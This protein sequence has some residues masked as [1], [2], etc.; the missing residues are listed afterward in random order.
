MKK[1]ITKITSKKVRPILKIQS[2]I[3][4]SVTEYLAMHGFLQALPVMLS[5]ETDPLAHPV[6]EAEIDYY[7]QKLKLTK[8]MILHKFVY[9]MASEID[10]IFIVS[11]NV[12][13]EPK[14]LSESQRHLIEFSQVDIEFKDKGKHFFMEFMEGLVVHVMQQVSS[15]CST[16]LTELGRKLKI[17][18]KPFRFYESKELK[19]NYGPDYEK[20]ISRLSDEPFWIL[21][22][23]REFYD[24][25]DTEEKGYHHNYDLVWPEGF[26]EALSG[27]EREYKYEEIVRKMEERDMDLSEYKSFLKLAKDRYLKRSVGGGLGVE[28]FVR[29]M[30][31][32]KDIDEVV[33]FP[34]KPGTRISL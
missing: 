2:V 13:L 7:R 19:E 4:R 25:E 28:R 27:G 16:E 21:D 15:Q 29:Y 9:M 10:R 24:R 30:T 33:F 8:S 34:R 18:K 1:I 32:L 14:E 6:S 20:E 17:P 31:G 11:P 5:P 26:G 12:R 22:H 3:L 23:M